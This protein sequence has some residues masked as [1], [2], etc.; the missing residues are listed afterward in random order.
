MLDAIANIV[1]II[2]AVITINGILFGLFHK[3][4]KKPYQA[5]V[6]KMENIDISTQKTNNEINNHLVP[7]MKSF[8]EEFSTN[9]GK[10][11]K[12]RITRI[13][14]SIKKEEIRNKL[15][16]D[17]LTMIGT[18]ECDNKGDCV[19]ANKSLCDMFG[20]NL[21]EMYG[22]GWLA[23]ICEEERTEV[24]VNWIENIKFNIPY[25]ATYKVCNL[26]TGEAFV[27]RTNAV[28]HRDTAGNIVGYY[29]TVVR[30]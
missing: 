3:Y 28:E 24:W 23:A 1:E 4:V 20:L 25:E 19:W 12:D 9:S 30:L 27:C 29:G 21:Q 6:A 11:I 7:F 15:L 13:D 16:A 14:N 22:R 2:I 10:S 18:Y 17:S 5:F 26:K 8:Q